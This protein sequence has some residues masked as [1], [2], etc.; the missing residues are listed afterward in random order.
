MTTIEMSI[1][2]TDIVSIY[3][4]VKIKLKKIRYGDRIP[5]Y[6]TCTHKYRGTVPVRVNTAVHR[7]TGNTA[8]P[9][10]NSHIMTGKRSEFIIII[11]YHVRTTASVAGMCAIVTKY[12]CAVHISVA[13]GRSH[14][15]V[16]GQE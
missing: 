12:D 5:R 16:I 13:V 11:I 3:H 4:S 7:Y 14:A 15:H 10:R 6:C 1:M 2:T 9:Y 8:Q